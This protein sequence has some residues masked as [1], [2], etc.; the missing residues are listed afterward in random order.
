MQL[1]VILTQMGVIAMILAIGYF[2]KATDRVHSRGTKDLSWLVINVCGPAQV[3]FS[4]LG[5]ENLPDK[6]KVT[7]FFFVVL[8]IYVLLI[9]LGHFLGRIIRAP[10]SDW[11]FFN[12]MAVF[13]NT[14]FLGLPLCQA[15]LG[16]DAM[17]YMVMFNLGYNIFFYTWALTLLQPEGKSYKFSPKSFLNP[18]AIASFSALILFFTGLRLPGIFTEFTRYLGNAVTF[19][20]VFVI[21]ANLADLSLKAI[22]KNVQGY[23]F[24]LLRG[25]L[26]PI[27]AVLIAKGLHVDP[28]VVGVLAIGLSVPVGNAPSMAA[29]TNGCD[30]RTLTE[31]TVMSTALCIFT[32]TIVL[33]VAM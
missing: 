20:S 18:G 5:A 28:L 26:I 13:G 30:V 4:V 24:I 15:I 31:V 22:L 23:L 12:V 9:F 19:M 14:G 33:L 11:K 25:V 32:M 2:C 29:A 10:R 8:G 21:G 16:N 7:R 1:S 6:G 27:I 17:I 3:L